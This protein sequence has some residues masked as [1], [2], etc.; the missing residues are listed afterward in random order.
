[1]SA[2]W[3]PVSTVEYKHGR[4]LPARCGQRYLI[5]LHV[6]QGKV[7]GFL[8][9]AHRLRA[10]RLVVWIATH[11]ARGAAGRNARDTQHQRCNPRKWH[12]V[13]PTGRILWWNLH[14]VGPARYIAWHLP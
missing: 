11:T 3:T 12:S 10:F 14:R 7:G 9:D 1:M 5:T 13:S 6:F 8:A 4:H 2:E